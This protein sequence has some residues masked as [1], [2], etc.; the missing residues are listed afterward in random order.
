MEKIKINSVKMPQ[1]QPTAH[2]S[3]IIGSRPFRYGN[4]IP[5]T[6]NSISANNDGLL[7]FLVQIFAANVTYN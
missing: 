5:G 2:N 4:N 7:Q 3:L 6:K 1:N